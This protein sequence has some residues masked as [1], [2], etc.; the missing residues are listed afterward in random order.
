MCK[1]GL[2]QK[3]KDTAATLPT[4]SRHPVALW[5]HG[6]HGLQ[7]TDAQGKSRL[8]SNA[9]WSSGWPRPFLRWK[10]ERGDSQSEKWAVEAHF[11]ST[12]SILVLR[13][14]SICAIEDSQQRRCISAVPLVTMK[15]TLPRKYS[16]CKCFSDSLA[17]CR[18]WQNRRQ[19]T[20][21]HCTVTVI[22]IMTKAR[23]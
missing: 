20:L 6:R 21:A 11:N 19:S 12:R 22:Y 16:G 4:S 13:F 17:E 10:R 2:R 14:H 15:Q 18:L 5:G 1:P 9:Q 8:D 7:E 23:Q 3:A